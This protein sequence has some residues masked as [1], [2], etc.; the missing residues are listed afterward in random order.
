MSELPGWPKL[1]RSSSREPEP[2]DLL[3]ASPSI[4]DPSWRRALILLLDQDES[5]AVGVII[6]RKAELDGDILPLW[7]GEAS[8]IMIGG[9]V[10]PEG[11][12]GICPSNSELAASAL[13]PDF[14]LMDLDKVES[15][16]ESLGAL[17]VSYP[18]RLYVGYAGWGPEQLATEIERGDWYVVKGE[19]SDVLRVEPDQA[20]SS[21]LHRQRPNVQA[22]ATLPDNP[23]MN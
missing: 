10:S 13:T 18:W 8:E 19:Q 2:G 4:A 7:V 9:P 16:I 1:P 5:G 12:I 14:G 22:W 11:L 6:N 20:W 23:E 17:Q 21:V 3:V 15:T